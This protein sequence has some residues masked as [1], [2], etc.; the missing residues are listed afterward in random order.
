MA[1]VLKG[2]CYVQKPAAVKLVPRVEVDQLHSLLVSRVPTQR[3]QPNAHLAHQGMGLGGVE[4]ANHHA[5]GGVVHREAKSLVP[6]EAAMHAAG[7][8][9]LVHGCARQETIKLDHAVVFPTALEVPRIQDVHLQ[10]AALLRKHRVFWVAEVLVVQVGAHLHLPIRLAFLG[11]RLALVVLE[12]VPLGRESLINLVTLDQREA[13]KVQ[14]H[15]PNQL[16]VCKV[17][18]PYRD[19]ELVV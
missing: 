3:R 6:L 17:L 2:N 12:S 19:G 7:T 10:P 9:L 8:P 14:V 16:V 15:P 18:V 1:R 4:Q 13:D 11:L 5:R